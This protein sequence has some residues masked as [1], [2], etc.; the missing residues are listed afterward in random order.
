MASPADGASGGL[1]ARLGQAMAG[2]CGPRKG[3][4]G[5]LQTAFV[6]AAGVSE[7]LSEHAKAAAEAVREARDAGLAGVQATAQAARST[8]A[9]A[10]ALLRRLNRLRHLPL[11]RLPQNQL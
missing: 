6:E 7:V 2:A 4:P 11:P 8:L 3:G 9:A 1:S 5:G 10:Q